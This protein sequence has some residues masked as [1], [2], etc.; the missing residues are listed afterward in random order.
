M[1]EIS[2][3]LTKPPPKRDYTNRPAPGPVFDLEVQLIGVDSNAFAL[4]ERVRKALMMTGYRE[5]AD[6]FVEQAFKCDSYEALLAYI[7]RTVHVT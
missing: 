4:I 3:D 2:L 1:S 5:D 6:H 7:A